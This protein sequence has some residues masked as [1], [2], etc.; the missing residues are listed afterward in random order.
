[1]KGFLLNIGWLFLLKRGELFWCLKMKLV[2][3]LFGLMVKLYIFLLC[4]ESLSVVLDSLFYVF[5][6]LL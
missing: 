6:V 4:L 3:C 1:M 2:V 5:G